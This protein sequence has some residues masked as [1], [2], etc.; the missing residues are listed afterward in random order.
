[1]GSGRRV[2]MGRPAPPPE[3]CPELGQDR[4]SAPAEG[5]RDPEERRLGLE[6]GRVWKEGAS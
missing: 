1:M 4:G 3:G 6:H 2:S 5:K